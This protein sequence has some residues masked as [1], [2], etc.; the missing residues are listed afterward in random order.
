MKTLAKQ[1]PVRDAPSAKEHR[2]TR[3][4]RGVSFAFDSR[5]LGEMALI[6]SC[7]KDVGSATCGDRVACCRRRQKFRDSMS[8]QTRRQSLV[9]GRPAPAALSFNCFFSTHGR[10]PQ[11]PMLAPHFRLC[12]ASFVY[13]AMADLIPEMHRG[14][15]HIA[16]P[17]QVTLV[18]AGVLTVAVL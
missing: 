12:V 14:S 6:N 13:V 5:S 17:W 1:T 15:I 8:Y 10:L 11:L 4:D 18:A 7:R 3:S 9:G 16:A 2:R